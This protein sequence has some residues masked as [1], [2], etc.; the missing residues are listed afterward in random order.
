MMDWRSLLVWWL[1]K[2][3]AQDQRAVHRLISKGDGAG[4]LA[5]QDRAQYRMEWVADL[6]KARR[7][8]RR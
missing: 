7:E 5:R 8:R 6:L 1:L 4:A 3:A 2:L